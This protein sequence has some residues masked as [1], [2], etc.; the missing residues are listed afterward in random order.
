[1]YVC[2]YLSIY[3]YIYIYLRAGAEKPKCVA[4]LHA[5]CQPTA[6]RITTSD[7][8]FASA[9]PNARASIAME[10]GLASLRIP[11]GVEGGVG[12][13]VVKGTHVMNLIM[14]GGGYGYG[15]F[16]NNAVHN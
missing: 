4:G 14:P 9:L 2:I 7:A 15:Q 1:M 8:E 3:I 10:R 12:G 6:A 16:Q 5:S 11:G 13:F